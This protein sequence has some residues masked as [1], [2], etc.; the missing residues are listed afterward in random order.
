[1]L[2]VAKFNFADSPSLSHRMG[3]GVRRT[4]DGCFVRFQFVKRSLFQ[5]T[6]DSFVRSTVMKLHLLLIAT[7]TMTRG[8]LVVVAAESLRVP[9]PATSA[10][11]ASFRH[12]IRHSIQIG[13]R[14]LEAQQ[15]T[16]GFWS[17]S[18]HPAITALAVRALLGDPTAGHKGPAEKGLRWIFGC[19]RPDGS[20]HRGELP[21]YNTA[22]SLLALHSSADPQYQPAIQKARRWL[23]SQQ[24]DLGEKGKL[25]SPFDGGVGYGGKYD[26]SD[27]NNTLVALE[28]LYY[29]RDH[30]GERNSSGPEALNWNAAI[31][32]LQNCQ[33]L[34]SYNKQP[35][36]S[37]DSTS[38]GGFVYYPGMSM[39][40]ADTNSDGH[41]ALRSYG[42]AS[43]AGLLSYIYADLKPD[44]PRVV[45][46]MDWLRRN[47]SLQENPGMGAQGLYY[48]LHLMTKAL[49]TAGVD[50]L[51]LADG[52]RLD[53][54]KEVAMKLINLQQANG[55][56]QNENGRW[57]EKDPVLVTSYS[58]LALEL[59][60][61]GL[62]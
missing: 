57:W 8:S 53:W 2:A 52:R 43:Y 3:E 22:L 20:I 47:F 58:L 50:R 10:A 14:W 48:Y 46:V 35:W 16:N 38:R 56:W 49:H 18:N 59:I 29:S 31:R 26:H 37:D 27:M 15:N 32:F 9:N 12:E 54:R 61:R 42:S 24:I 6:K 5:H 34:P 21:N 30:H 7:L 62:P 36:V 17:I 40:G 33:Q 45:A 44:D 25:D 60:D 51:E 23:V 55:S 19:S 28:A 1:M 11:N 41:V 4:G 13:A 39:A